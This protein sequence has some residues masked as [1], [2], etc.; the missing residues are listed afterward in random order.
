VEPFVCRH[1]TL[2]PEKIDCTF[3]KPVADGKDFR[4]DYCIVFPSRVRKACGYGADEV[5]ALLLAM[6]RAHL[7]LLTAPERDEIELL[8]FGMKDLGLP[9]PP[10]AVADNFD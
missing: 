6:Q 10:D 8:W 3:S 9:L 7:D 4:C 2:G 5:Q 1:F